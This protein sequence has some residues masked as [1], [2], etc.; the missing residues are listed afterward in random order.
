[1]MSDGKPLDFEEADPEKDQFGVAA[2]RAVH[3]EG[4]AR[5]L[6]LHRVR[7]VPVAVPGLEHRQAAV[8]EAAGAVAA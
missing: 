6:H 4:A 2:G 7:P 5:L 1:M 8:A 3:L